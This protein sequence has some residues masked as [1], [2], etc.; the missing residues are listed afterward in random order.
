MT[1]NNSQILDNSVKPTAM[2]KLQYNKLYGD[3][4]CKQPYALTC[5]KYETLEHVKNSKWNS[6]RE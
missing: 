4:I 1:I 3:S 5:D 6:L 2:T